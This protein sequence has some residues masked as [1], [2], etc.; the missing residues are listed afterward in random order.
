[1]KLIKKD[2]SQQKTMNLITK[3]EL[4]KEESYIYTM[5]VIL[6]VQKITK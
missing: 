1:M 2:N 5:H 6:M 3:L 4:N